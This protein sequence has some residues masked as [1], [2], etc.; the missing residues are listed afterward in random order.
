MPVALSLQKTHTTDSEKDVTQVMQTTVS[1]VGATHIPL[2]KHQ[3]LV[4]RALHRAGCQLG[5]PNLKQLE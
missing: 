2:V 5:L 4:Q 3:T 1:G